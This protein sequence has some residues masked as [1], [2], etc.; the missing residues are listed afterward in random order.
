MKR[1]AV[2]LCLVIILPSIARSG[3]FQ[4]RSEA[5]TALAAIPPPESSSEVR[6]RTFDVVWNTIKNKHFDPSFGGL[7]WD[8]I[9]TEYAPKAEAVKT[10]QELYAVLQQMLG[11]LHQSHFNIIPPE[12]IVADDAKEPPTAGIGVKVKLID[13]QVLITKVEKGS[14]AA[15]AGVRPGFI[16]GLV[17]QVPIQDLIN[18]MVEGENSPLAHNRVARTVMSMLAGEPGTRVR[19]NC[20]DENLKLRRLT[21][22]RVKLASEM[23]PRYGNFPPQVTEFEATRLENGIGYIRFNIFVLSVMDRIRA[24]IKSMNDAPGLV[25]DLRGN[26]GGLGGMSMGLAGM[27]NSRQGSLGTMRLRSGH[28]NFV[29]SPQKDRYSGPMV[30]L[31]DEGSASTSEVF[32]AGMQELGRSTVVGQRSAGAALP[33]LFE[34][35]PT[36]AVLQYAFAD[37]KTPKGKVI[38]G[39]GVTPDVVVLLTRQA[40]LQGRDPQLEVAIA[41]IVKTSLGP[42]RR[43]AA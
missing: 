11:E 41:H 39:L 43:R 38:E 30:I 26:P 1:L 17:D 28:Q 42:A 22:R 9:R 27:L 10:D 18:R 6:M 20:V 25:I 2:L 33:S 14:P 16:V 36:G 21:L 31:I 35:L 3:A 8:R 5:Q 4:T 13:R 40:L 15:R 24:A 37:F 12:K 32:A 34:K 23:S 19:M 7:D 29:F